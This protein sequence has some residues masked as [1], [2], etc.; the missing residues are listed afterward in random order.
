MCNQCGAC[1]VIGSSAH[2]EVTIANCGDRGDSPVQGEDVG[3]ELGGP[4]RQQVRVHAQPRALRQVL[5]PRDEVV[6]APCRVT[7]PLLAT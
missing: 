6:C 1:W 7:P 2:M 4:G 5:L 3:V